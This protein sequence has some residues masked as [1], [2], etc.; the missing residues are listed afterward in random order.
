PAGTVS[1]A[2][3]VRAM[4]IIDELEVARR[5]YY[6]GGGWDFSGNG[7][8]DTCIALRTALGKDG[9]LFVPAGAGVVAGNKPEAEHQ[10]WV[11]KAQGL[12]MAA[13]MALSEAQTVLAGK[14]QSI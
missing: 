13:E 10:E 1:G 14:R 7:T 12:I 11:N 4:Q 9:K 2:P 8:L 5:S 6:G 3:K